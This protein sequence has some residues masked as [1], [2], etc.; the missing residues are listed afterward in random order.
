MQQSSNVR[1]RSEQA[2]RD[3]IVMSPEHAASFKDAHRYRLASEAPA[4]FARLRMHEYLRAPRKWLA[5]I[6]GRVRKR[7]NE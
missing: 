1:A 2:F 5:S 7:E 4:S 3:S 6:N